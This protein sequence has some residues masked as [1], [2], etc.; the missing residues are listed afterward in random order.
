MNHPV[1][2][3][4]NGNEVIHPVI[5]SP[6]SRGYVVDGCGFPK[7]VLQRIQSLAEFLIAHLA[8]IS[9]PFQHR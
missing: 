3:L 4:A 5:P 9:V 2:S 1:A 6:E 7:V 8:N